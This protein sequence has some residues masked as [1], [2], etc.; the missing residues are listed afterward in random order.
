MTNKNKA[1]GSSLLGCIVFRHVAGDNASAYL[2]QNSKAA[3]WL[4]W[5]DDIATAATP[6]HLPLTPVH[7]TVNWPQGGMG[8]SL[9]IYAF[10]HGWCITYYLVYRHERATSIQLLFRS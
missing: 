2:L 1:L 4:S 7:L 10:R 6:P 8:R 5:A 3:G 9:G